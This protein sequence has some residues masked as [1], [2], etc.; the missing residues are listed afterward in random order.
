[1]SQTIEATEINSALRPPLSLD[2]RMRL[3]IMM[4]LE[5]AIWGAWFIFFSDYCK[6]T[7]NLDGAQVGS[8]Y[9]TVALGAIISMM[10]AGQIADRLIPAQ[11][12]LVICHLGGAALLFAMFKV[13]TYATLWWVTLAYALLYNPTLSL[14]NTVAFA[15]VPDPAR[16]FPTLRVMGTL[17]WIAAASAADWVQPAGAGITPRPLLYAAAYSAVLGLFCF[18]LPNTPPPAARREGIPFLRALRL[19]GDRSFG[20]FFII[21]FIAVS[22]ALGFYYTFIGTFLPDVH[23]VHFGT[24]STLGQCSEVLFMLLLPLALKR[25]GMKTVVLVGMAAWVGRYIAFAVPGHPKPWVLLGVALHGVSFDFF[26]AAGF[27]YTEEKAPEAIRGSAQALFGFIV[28]GVGMWAG[29][30][31]SGQVNK[32]YTVNGI[33]DWTKIW[34]IPAVGAAVCFLLFLLL[35]RERPNPQHAQ[36]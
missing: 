1:M 18:A 21:T 2:V 20:P 33:S 15:H 27:I 28:Y 6:K 24:V 30:M 3:S 8:I 5:F 4:F 22:I 34:A 10:F 17:G 12:L 13:H 25:L 16:D 23:F 9:G 31:I 29:N 7:L 11:Y 36:A 32:H 26:L 14:V 35:W 19:L